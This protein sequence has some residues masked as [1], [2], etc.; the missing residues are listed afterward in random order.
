MKAGTNSDARI[1]QLARSRVYLKV[2]AIS[3]R[4]QFR[5]NAAGELRR[6]QRFPIRVPLRYRVVGEA[7]WREGTTV[8]ISS[9]GVFFRCE[10]TAERAMRM[11]I[12]FVLSAA[13]N[14]NSGAE[15]VCSGEVVRLEPSQEAGGLPAL[16][17][18]IMGY[19]L[20]PWLGARG[21]PGNPGSQP[22]Y[23]A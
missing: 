11:E 10:Q 3:K 21:E 23:K 2:T 8:N 17:M 16:A 12:D 7:D 20:L 4:R 14:E 15:V 5:L 19:R 6:A 13:P 9:A 18:N 22:R 1:Q